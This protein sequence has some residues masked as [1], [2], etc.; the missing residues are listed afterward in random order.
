MQGRP[1]IEVLFE[2]DM[3][4]QADTF[5]RR[6]HQLRT[7]A[8]LSQYALAKKSGV[9]KQYLSELERGLKEPSLAVATLL[10]HALDRRLDCWDE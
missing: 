3:L 6:L 1:L 2:D 5:A 10:A 9:S 8:G 4:Q 7:A